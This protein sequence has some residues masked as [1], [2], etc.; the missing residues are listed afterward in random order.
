[1]KLLAID[2]N[3]IMN[4][5]YYGIKQLSTRD[6]IATNAIQGFMN[7]YFRAKGEIAPEAVAVAFDLRE[8]TF[9]HKACDTY[10]ANRHG[11]DDDLAVQMPYI[12]EI[13]RYMGITVL[14]VPG[15][16]ADD[17]LGTLST[18]AK[19]DDHCYILTGDRDSLQLLNDNV[20]VM[21]HTTR[22]LINFTP[23][24]FMQEYEGLRPAQLVDLK[25]LMGDSS[26]NISGVKGIGEK[27]A[28]GLI[29]TFGTIDS[30][31]RNLDEG[32]TVG[33]KSVMAKLIDG[34]ESA[35]MSRYLAEIVK[36][37]PIE[38]NIFAYVCKPVDG[39]A[40][41]SVLSRLEMTKIIEKLKLTA[42]KR[43]M[44]KQSASPIDFE[45]SE[46]IPDG[47]MT[48]AFNGKKILTVCGKKCF[49]TN[50]E[51]LIQKILSL[52]YK[53]R[54]FGAKRAYR[55]CMKNGIN[56]ENVVSDAQI[57][58]YLLNTNEK[59]YTIRQLTAEI[60]CNEYEY[61]DKYTE[62]CQLEEL[63]TILD[64]RVAEEGLEKLY[65]EIELPL[66]KVLASMEYY[67]IRV[68]P[69][70]IKAFGETLKKEIGEIEQRI[71][72]RAGHEFNV[73][74]PKQLAVVL[75]DELG[76]PSGKKTKHGYSTNADVLTDLADKDPIVA[77]V[78]QYRQYMKLMSTYVDGLL[79]Q[80]DDTGR[81]HTVFKQTETRTGRISST[82]P[83]LQ[84][85]PVRTELGRNMRRFFIA[86]SGKKLIDADYSQIELRILAHLADDENMQ[87]SFCG[88]ADIHAATASQVFGVPAD[89]VTP[90][91][92][93]A[94]KAV[95]FGI[96]YGISAFS[97]SKDINVTQREAQQY[98]K[99]YL[100][101]FHGVRDF[102]QSS[103]ESAKKLGYSETL[104]GRRRYIPELTSKNN[105]ILQFGKR[106]AMNAPVQGTAADVIKI[107]MIRVFDRLA[108]ELP[109][110]HLV[111]Q[112]HDELIIEASEEDAP[113]AAR[114]L[115]EE[116]PA[117][118]ELSVPLVT[119]VK[120]GDSWFDTH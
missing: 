83:N 105:N 85:I 13:L 104:Y 74:S 61:M 90:E 53:K 25:G 120:I 48:F 26:D 80:V 3:S 59:E 112:I 69:D 92:R 77:D 24:R 73:A 17:I 96:V 82:E 32:H 94:A 54:T 1:M 35:S 76:L 44:P 6:G 62:V 86:D 12:K 103:V 42:P 9:R 114:I 100:D 2:G 115:A 111:L 50:D 15:F 52:P 37:V 68:D 33:T 106:A 75:F 89:K 107:A 60:G 27:T 49:E 81:I 7:I 20:T 18:L 16:E 28:M 67:G 10:K 116:M 4:R 64:G 58:A 19:G 36:D 109:D 93:R 11:M 65:R 110:A 5:A 22:E 40:L 34:R 45:V 87:K 102:M 30:I 119:D 57:A 95:N 78:L 97:L 71:Y 55:Y 31:Y 91:M 46:S 108:K 47:D 8:P 43:M 113:K 72:F 84:N 41:A 56:L 29:K 14:E 88:G 23:E 117:A 66:T 51:A 101:N 98:I 70:G 39:D 21:L 99:N 79:K 63:C 118:A 38:K